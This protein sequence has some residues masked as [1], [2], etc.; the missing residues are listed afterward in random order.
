MAEATGPGTRVR[1]A[2]ILV[3]VAGL[4][5]AVL[6]ERVVYAS[7]LEKAAALLHG[8][9]AWRPLEMWNTGLA[10]AAAFGL[11]TRHGF[12]LAISPWEQMVITDEISSGRLED[13]AEIALRLSPFLELRRGVQG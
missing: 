3:S 6:M 12:H 2:G 9:V 11:L 7:L 5:H 8:I 13:V 10:W 1:D 4:P